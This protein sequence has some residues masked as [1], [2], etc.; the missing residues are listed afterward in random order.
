MTRAEFAT[1]AGGFLVLGVIALALV[2]RNF[3]LPGLYYDEAIQATPALSFLEEDGDPLRIPGASSTRVFGR[4][5]PV[6]TQP[7]M[8]ALKSQLLIPTFA[9]FGA[10]PSSLRATTLAWGLLGVV[11]SVLWVRRI[12]DL[13]T[14]LLAG[15]LVALDPSF[16][17]IS[18]HDWGSFALGLVC[19]TGGLLL[20]TSGWPGARRG[21]LL[22]GGLALGLWLYNK[23]DFGVFLAAAAL[24]LASTSPAVLREALASWRGRALPLA[25]GFSVGALPML[26][27]LGRAVA[28]ASEFLRRADAGPPEWNEKIRTLAATLDGSYFHRLMLE[29]GSFERMFEAEGAAS[30]PLLGVFAFSA[31]WVG[32]RVVQR[33]RAGEPDRAAAFAL[34]TALFTIAGVLLTPGAVRIHHVLNVYPFPHLVVA[35]AIVGI[36][37]L[38]APPD[39]R[40]I[41]LRAVAVALAL[42]VLA[43]NIHVGRR[44]LATIEA[45]GGKGRWSDALQAF[46]R[47]L[48][49]EAGAVAVGLDWGF[50]APLELTAPR[51]EI[52]EP[53]WRMRHVPQGGAGWELRGTARH[54]YLVHEAPYA[55][56][57][58][59]AALLEA[60]RDLP[61]GAVH[62]RRH[63]D[64]EGDPAF[65]SVRFTRPHDLLYRGGFVVTLR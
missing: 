54:R 64:R 35:I 58:V 23:I 1:L 17:F 34:A 33:A 42:A 60:V 62:I 37:R 59:G 53:I 9:L 48:E 16:L 31:L 29:G 18:R 52:E 11:F 6:M 49:G 65:V 15:A 20:V 27:A 38:R 5:L 4:W 24:A 25:L 22:V 56:F 19:R 61:P 43:G 28:T 8:G 51:L 57:D 40:R 50:R 7:Y 2:A 55:V 3:E 32:W 12:L 13:P 63:L 44:T 10:T 47:E 39:P 36:W 21:R 46:G 41:A 30:G 14:A 26:A 45:T